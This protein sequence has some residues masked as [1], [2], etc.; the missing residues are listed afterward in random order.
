ESSIFLP[1]M[2]AA[3]HTRSVTQNP[4]RRFRGPPLA[5][6]HCHEGTYPLSRHHHRAASVRANTGSPTARRTIGT[7]SPANESSGNPGS[8]PNRRSVPHDSGGPTN[9]ESAIYA[10][11]WNATVYQLPQEQLHSIR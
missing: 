10:D 7:A 5:Y 9:S 3:A 1:I 8:D 11:E 6:M 2:N 4:F